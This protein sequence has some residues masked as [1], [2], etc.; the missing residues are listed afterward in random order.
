[1]SIQ[2]E[3]FKSIEI[4]V[5]KYLSKQKVSKTIP[6]TIEDVSGDTYKCNID[7]RY[8]NL[9]N[10]SGAILTTGTAVWIHIPNGVIGNAFIMGTR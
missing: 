9:K 7:G 4:L 6:S 8:Y 3:L 5:E 10:G 2:D 1:M